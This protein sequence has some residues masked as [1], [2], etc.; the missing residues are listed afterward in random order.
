MDHQPPTTWTNA[1]DGDERAARE[2]WSALALDGPTPTAE[3][4]VD[5]DAAWRRI[6]ARVAPRARVVDL[7]TATRR[8]PS[9]WRYA[10]AAAAALLLL[11]LVNVVAG[12]G[13]T[14]A[15]FANVTEEAMPVVLPDESEATLMPGSRLAYAERDGRREVSVR[16]EVGFAVTRDPAMTFAVEAEQLEVVVIG[17]KFRVN[18]A[19]RAGVAVTEGHV[20]V[21]G[22]READWTDLYAG[23]HALVEDGLVVVSQPHAS[24][25][26]E[27]H[28]QDTPLSEVLRRLNLHHETSISSAPSLAACRITARLANASA[29]DAARTIALTL[30]ARVESRASGLKIVGGGCE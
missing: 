25:S 7:H 5:V 19:G 1:L 21:R 9:R 2:L 29:E 27:L 23:G 3:A 17:T 6:S 28:F 14:S 15:E 4:D 24:S 20:R 12:L 8:K 26:D 22:R 30:G 11:A 13:D 10:A 18:Q 16:G